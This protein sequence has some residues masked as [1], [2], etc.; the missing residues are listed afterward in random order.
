MK[1]RMEERG[2]AFDEE[3]FK[4]RMERRMERRGNRG[5]RGDT[6][7]DGVVTLAEMEERALQRFQRVDT[8]GNGLISADEREA[9]KEKR[10]ERR[11]KHR[12]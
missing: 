5:L 1:A 11:A 9:M 10:K 6:N 7:G 2:R 3:K 4:A 12:G 8:D